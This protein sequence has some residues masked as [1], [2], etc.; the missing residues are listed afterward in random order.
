MYAFLKLKL[1]QA[2]LITATSLFLLTVNLMLH[3]PWP[4]ALLRITVTALAQYVVIVL[5]TPAV[6][7]AFALLQ[8]WRERPNP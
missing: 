6:E 8:R 7:A 3:R 1:H 4:D 2:A 5:T